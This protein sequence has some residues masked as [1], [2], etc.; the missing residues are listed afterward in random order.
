MGR[1]DV[2]V[3]VDGS[4]YRFHPHFHDL[5]MEKTEHLVNPGIK[6]RLMLSHDGSGKGAALVAA[7]AHRVEEEK[8]KQ[9]QPLA[10]G[11][12]DLNLNS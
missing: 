10:R 11:V 12:K 4:L 5:M 7:V 8:K 3:A 9:Q 6:F 1:E 2:A